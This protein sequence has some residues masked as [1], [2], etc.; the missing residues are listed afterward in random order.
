MLQKWSRLIMS[1]TSHLIPCEFLN[2]G[3][4]K[5]SLQSTIQFIKELKKWEI[6]YLLELV[7]IAELYDEYAIML[8][9][10]LDIMHPTL[11]K[12]TPWICYWSTYWA[13]TK[14]KSSCPSSLPN[15]VIEVSRIVEISCWMRGISDHQKLPAAH[16]ICSK[17]YKIGQCQF[18][19]WI[20]KVKTMTGEHG[21]PLHRVHLLG[22]F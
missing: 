11:E 1:K 5:P 16:R 20:R 19:L 8:E 6:S 4:S 21:N 7:E 18:A 3:K 15:I 14:C 9:E 10:F 17:K 22:I 2:N 12:A 13:R